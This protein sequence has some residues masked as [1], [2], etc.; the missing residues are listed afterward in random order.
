MIIRRSDGPFGFR[1]ILGVLCAVASTACGEASIASNRATLLKRDSSGVEIVILTGTIDPTPLRRSEAI[2]VATLDSLEIDELRQI[3]TAHL[4]GDGSITL[5]STKPLRVVLIDS[6]GRVLRQLGRAGDGPGEY[7][8]VSTIRRLSDGRV[9]L[10]D[11]VNRRMTE[12]ADDG[13]VSTVMTF[14]TVRERPTAALSLPAGVF[15][16]GSVLVR[17][18]APAAAASGL[19]RPP[20]EFVRLSHGGRVQ[21]LPGVL[22]GDEVFMGA[23]GPNGFAPIGVPPFGRKVLAAV[24]GD[25]FVLAENSGFPVRWQSGNGRLRREVQAQ[26]V[27]QFLSHRDYIEFWR[28]NGLDKPT[29]VDVKRLREMTPGDSLPAIRALYCAPDNQLLIEFETK[30]LDASRILWWM[31]AGATEPIGYAVPS[32]LRLLS[33]A[34]DGLLVAWQ[35]NE[36]RVQ[37]GRFRLG[38]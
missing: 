2:V 18:G 4:S 10:F 3:R 16:D 30:P 31:P 19:S 13:Q 7:R 37:L 26:V 5:A 33:V 21:M 25:D 1:G 6:T 14:A 36:T 9:V 32:E 11:P 8:A 38:R 29:D 28:Q 24:C 34:R 12:F 22:D 20:F 17:A 27:R 15:D 23:P 35:E